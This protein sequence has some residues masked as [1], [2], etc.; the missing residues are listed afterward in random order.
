MRL[1]MKEQEMCATNSGHVMQLQSKCWQGPADSIVVARGPWSVT[2]MNPQSTE[3]QLVATL[4]VN[5]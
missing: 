4:W 3:E 1:D 2:R 5:P